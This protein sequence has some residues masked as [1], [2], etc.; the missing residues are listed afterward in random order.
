MLILRS[1]DGVTCA[2]APSP[3]PALLSGVGADSCLAYRNRDNGVEASC[4]EIDYANCSHEY[5]A[6]SFLWRSYSES[7][8]SRNWIHKCDIEDSDTSN[9]PEPASVGSDKN[10]ERT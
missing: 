9:G 10:K 1:N 4:Q 5:D 7:L 3:N 8:R 2:Y 6:A